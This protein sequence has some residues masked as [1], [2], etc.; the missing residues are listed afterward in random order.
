MPSLYPAAVA[1][2]VSQ[3]NQP[4]TLRRLSKNDLGMALYWLRSCEMPTQL[5]AGNSYIATKDTIIFGFYS[6]CNVPNG[7]VIAVADGDNCLTVEIGPH[8]CI[9]V[10]ENCLSNDLE[11]I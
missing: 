11:P 2:R 5:K 6:G 1:L 9:D 10:H 4:P 3:K 7:H 8:I